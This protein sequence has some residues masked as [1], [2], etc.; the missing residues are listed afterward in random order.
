MPNR[1]Q[2]ILVAAVCAA[3]FAVFLVATVA[4]GLGPMAVDRWWADLLASTHTS[5]MTTVQTFISWL[6]GGLAGAVIIP[7]AVVVGLV[8][9]RK[10]GA[11]VTFAVAVFGS[12]V[13]VQLIKHVVG[14]PRP[15]GQQIINDFASFPS[16]HVTNAATIAVVVALLLRK[17]FLVVVAVIWMAAMAFSRTYL[18]VHWL[19]DTLA[20][21]CLGTCAAIVTVLLADFVASRFRPSRGEHRSG[22]PE[23]SSKS[24]SGVRS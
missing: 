22:S 19:T 21:C 14:R 23:L 17:R 13:T 5:A 4:T 18:Q 20:G 16:G 2:L 7:G 6:G 12:A 15:A 10:P 8:V 1:R 11:A 3:L 9:C 24:T